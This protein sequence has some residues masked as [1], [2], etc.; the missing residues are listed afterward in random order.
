[1]IDK[2]KAN[3]RLFI[4]LVTSAATAA[5]AFGL[6]L[7]GEQVAAVTGLTVAATSFLVGDSMADRQV[8]KGDK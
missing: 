5:A 6:K 1:M 8:T 2:I 7:T 3:P 4:T